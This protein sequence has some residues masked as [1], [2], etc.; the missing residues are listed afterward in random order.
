VSSLVGKTYQQLVEL[1]YPA[2]QQSDFGAHG[3]WTL[4]TVNH[5]GQWLVFTSSNQMGADGTGRL[6]D[7]S[8]VLSAEALAPPPQGDWYGVQGVL[9]NGQP[10]G[11][12]MMQGHGQEREK[13]GTYPVTAA[14]RVNLQTLKLEPTSTAG[15]DIMES[16][17]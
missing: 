14:W 12:V 3:S 13:D 10:I 15:L 11:G 5:D 2:H 17:G 16:C 4:F 9:R 7:A 1:G 6:D 8:K